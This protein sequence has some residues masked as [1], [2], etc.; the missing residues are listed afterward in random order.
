MKAAHIR[1]LGTAC[2]VL[3]YPFQLH[4]CPWGGVLIKLIGCLLVLFCM[5]RAKMYDQV[6]MC[7]F[8][9]SIDLHYLLTTLN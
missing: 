2:L 1:T 7:A 3:G 6:G 4:L 8:C 5:A 9:G